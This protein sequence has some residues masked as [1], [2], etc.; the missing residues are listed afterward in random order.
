MARVP[1]ASHRRWFIVGLLFLLQIINY[2]DRQALS[3][4][5]PALRDQLGF[6][7]EQYS[8]IVTCF[9]VAYMIGFAAGGRMLDVFGV[10][11]TLAA[12]V[13]VWSVAGM[14]HAAARTWVHLAAARLLLG[15][16]E[17]VGPTGGAKAIGEWIPKRERGLC[18]AIFSNGL[19]TGAVIAP[20]LVAFLALKSGWQAAFLITGALGFLWLAV[21]LLRYYPPEADPRLTE[22]ERAVILAGRDQGQDRSAS[23][24]E[25]LSNPACYSLLLARFLTDPVPYFF[26]F[27]LP[28]YL[29]RSHDF[30]VAL[31]GMVAWIPYLAA[32]VGGL[33][34]GAI[35]DVLVRRGWTPVRARRRLMLVAACLTPVAALAVRADS[36]AVAL[37]CIGVVLAAHSCWTTNLQTFMTERF[38][39]SQVGT[40]IGLSG[41]GSSLGGIIAMLLTGVIVARHGY[42]PVFTVLGA[43]HAT[44]FVLLSL[45]NPTKKEPVS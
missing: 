2:V 25:V 6:S 34:G 20:P 8:Y 1:W 19:A 18:M 11:R 42:V 14:L 17:A 29:R 12:A 45:M 4:L 28:E 43:M 27:W 21:W 13:C 37:A 32:D 38:P 44:A 24:R 7:T 10:K 9:L 30:S 16:G 22:P 41:V 33:S 35:S 36:A 5:A 3:V 26:T 23:W 39:R 31:I 40:V 15:L